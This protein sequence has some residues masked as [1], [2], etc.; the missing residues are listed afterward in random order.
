VLKSNLLSLF[1]SLPL[2]KRISTVKNLKAVIVYSHH[3]IF[4][5]FV[6]REVLKPLKRYLLLLFII[7]N[8]VVKSSKDAPKSNLNF[9]F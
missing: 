6:Y 7:I 3:L 9:V 1:K 5:I 4:I 8:R 2:L